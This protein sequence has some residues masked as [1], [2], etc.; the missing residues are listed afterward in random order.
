MDEGKRERLVRMRQS[1]A[2]AGLDG[3]VCRLPENL[4]CLTGYWPLSGVSFFMLPRDG[5]PVI[6]ALATEAEAGLL[7]SDISCAVFPW[8]KVSDPAPLTSILR[9]LRGRGMS[10]LGW[11]G[12]F[13][14]VAP[15]HVAGEVLVPARC[16][17]AMLEEA[18]PRAVLV[19]ATAVLSR[20]RAVKLP[21]D[22][23]GLRRVAAV[24]ERAVLAF[25]ASF[26][27]G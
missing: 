26:A 18:F 20:E 5:D 10:R 21:A 12:A 17:A 15:A 2:E 7:P 4:L 14:A 27:L 6:I 3:L 25:E 9:L 1:L 11:E 13:E 8:G 22:V 19:D 24:A 16:T 23:E